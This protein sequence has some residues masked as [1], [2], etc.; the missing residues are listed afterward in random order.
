MKHSSEQFLNQFLHLQPRMQ[1]LAE[2]ILHNEDLAA[3]IVQD[4]FVSLWNHRSNLHN[5][6]NLESWCLTL[7]RNRSIDYLRRQHQPIPISDFTEEEDNYEERLLIA[8]KLIQRLPSRQAKVVIMKHFEA[9]DTA[10]IAKEMNITEGNV[11]TLLSRAY[12]T[13][14]KLVKDEEL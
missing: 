13:L 7:V 1:R 2:S 9:K 3:D 11:Y 4:C 12:T 14:K 10:H 5:I 6:Q 8:Q